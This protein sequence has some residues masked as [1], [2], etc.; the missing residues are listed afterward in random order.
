MLY[1]KYFGRNVYYLH[2]SSKCYILFLKYNK[3]TRTKIFV[4]LEQNN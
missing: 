3:N 1:T 4:S 2:T